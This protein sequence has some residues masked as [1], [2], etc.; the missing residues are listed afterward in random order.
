MTA[1]GG[2]SHY[3]HLTQPWWYAPDA[4]VDVICFADA[5][6][7]TPHHVLVAFTSRI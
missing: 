1:Q 3:C 2:G 4:P 5:G 6:V 7:P